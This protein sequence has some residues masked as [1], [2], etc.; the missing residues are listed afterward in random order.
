MKYFSK[1][2]FIYQKL[3]INNGNLQ[4]SEFQ[5]KITE[6]CVVLGEVEDNIVLR[7]PFHSRLCYNFEIFLKNSNFFII[8]KKT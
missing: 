6:N 5:H 3:Y 8:V 7:T 4:F 1:Y 2:I